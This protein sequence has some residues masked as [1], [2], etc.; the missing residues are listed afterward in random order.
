MK[1]REFFLALGGTAVFPPTAH[2]QQRGPMRRIGVL[3][4]VAADDP[5]SAGRIAAFLKELQQF[6]W[7]DGRNVQIDARWAVGDVDRF[8]QYA[9]ELIALAPDAVLASSSLAVA[10]LQKV[11]GTVPIVF[12][13]VVDPVGAGFVDSLAHPRRKHHRVH[14]FRIRPEREM[15]GA[16]ERDCTPRETSSGPSG[17]CLTCRERY[18]HRHPIGGAIV[19][20]GV[21]PIL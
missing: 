21:E 2:A 8:R 16:V 18:V 20:S 19:W 10:A 9:A 17:S 14:E 11:T 12:V 7:S 13:G 1:R 15:A 4:N 5:E 3:M 6:G